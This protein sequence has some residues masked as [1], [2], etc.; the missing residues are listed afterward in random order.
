MVA[1]IESLN[2]PTGK[3]TPK[4]LQA[5]P[6]LAS[7]MTGKDIASAINVNPATVSLWINHDLKFKTALDDFSEYSL[8]LAK[9]QLE[10]LTGEA[11]NELRDLLKNAK[12]ERV[13]LQAI[14]LVMSSVGLNASL[15]KFEGIGQKGIGNLVTT[16]AG[17][18]DF[19]KLIEAVTGE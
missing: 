10:S 14:E 9:L 17:R 12:S 7:G 13:R 1:Y 15:V 6:L 5:I 19:N 3:L 18:Y 16:N 8:R 11:V 2:M 4:Q